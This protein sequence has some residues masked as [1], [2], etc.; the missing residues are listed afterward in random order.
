M[1]IVQAVEGSS[2]SSKLLKHST[3]TA[4]IVSLI[5]LSSLYG[6]SPSHAAVIN[7]GFETDDFT[8][9]NTIGD[10]SIQ[11]AKFGIV[12]TD[13]ASQALLSSA[14]LAGDFFNFSGT[15]AV[16]SSNLEAFLGIPAGSLSSLENGNSIEGSAIKQTFTANVGDVLSFDFNFLTD[17]DTPNP[18]FND[19]AFAV[20]QPST[21][22]L[23]DTFSTF[24]LSSF[25]RQETGFQTFSTVLATSGTYTLGLGIVD[26]GDNAITSGLLVDNIQSTASVPEPS[27]TL[28]VLAFAALGSGLLLKRK[29]LKCKQ[30][31]PK[32]LISLSKD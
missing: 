16:D 28:G 22:E 21:I 24:N 1:V 4:W 2:G 23:A 26:V 20:L 14:S 5:S 3:L 30:W 19:F 6:A 27:S 9:F 15:D 10:T 8:G 32:E 31:L 18:N 29:V 12:P 25:F 7:G 13:G 11:T 17:D